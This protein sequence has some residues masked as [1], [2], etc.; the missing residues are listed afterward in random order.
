MSPRGLIATSVTAALLATSGLARAGEDAAAG[1]EEIVSAESELEGHLAEIR[2]VVCA[3]DSR[4]CADLEAFA[5]ATPP[6]FSDGER[7]IVGH[8]YLLGDDGHVLPAEYF[9]LQSQTAGEVTLVQTR[10]VFSES[11]QEKEAA[12]AFIVGLREGRLDTDNALYRYLSSDDSA[13][14]QVMG[15][16]EQRSLVVRG[17]GPAIYLRQ[18]GKLIYAAIPE[19]AVRPPGNTEPQAGVLF[20]VLPAPAACE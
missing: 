16:R 8:A 20:A 3:G 10:Q 18:A 7:I 17:K 9:V 1:H 2:P 5:G 13:P 11:A 12:E 6:C 19:V 14:P 4:L 15:E